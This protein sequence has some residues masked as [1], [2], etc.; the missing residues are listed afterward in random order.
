MK[1]LL[2]KLQPTYLVPINA[3]PTYYILLRLHTEYQLPSLFNKL[4][5]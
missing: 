5:A 1:Y 4:I 3:Y 2:L